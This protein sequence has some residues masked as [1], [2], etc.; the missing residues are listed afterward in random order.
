ML[1]NHWS[2]CLQLCLAPESWDYKIGLQKALTQA[3]RG[4]NHAAP[5]Q[6]MNILVESAVYF[7]FMP[8]WI[9]L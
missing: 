3:P 9:T 5:Y 6:L 1:H 8:N 2:A 7:G 4:K